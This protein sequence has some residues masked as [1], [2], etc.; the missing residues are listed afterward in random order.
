[1][2]HEFVECVPDQLDENV[3]YISMN[4]ATAVHKC[5]CGCGREVVTPL[6]PTDWSFTFNGD[7]VSLDHSIGNWSFPCR[8]H[9]FI[10]MSRIVWAGPMSDEEIAKGRAWDVARKTGHF[11][12]AEAVEMKAVSPATRGAWKKFLDWLKG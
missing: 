12:T 2:R 10:E 5:A 9:Y 8:S 3:L 7:A 4:Y 11:G 6:S 1:M